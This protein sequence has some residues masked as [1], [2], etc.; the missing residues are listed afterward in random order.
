MSASIHEILA[1][2]SIFQERLDPKLRD[3]IGIIQRVEDDVL[4]NNTY[5]PTYG[6]FGRVLSGFSVCE[7]YLR[8]TEDEFL[9]KSVHELALLFSSRVAPLEEDM[10]D[11]SANI[12]RVLEAGGLGGEYV[13]MC[14]YSLAMAN[15][16]YKISDIY[17]RSK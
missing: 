10:K 12:A 1:G 3:I 5:S 7:N 9:E 17:N 11:L 2:A 15:S 16:L 4:A 13:Y 14:G 6:I 8:I